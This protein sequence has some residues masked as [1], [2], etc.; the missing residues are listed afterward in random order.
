MALEFCG[1]P[2]VPPKQEQLSWVDIVFASRIS[3]GSRQEQIGVW[4]GS[5]S[6]ELCRVRAQD[7]HAWK[8]MAPSRVLGT[9][10]VTGPSWICRR[11]PL[12]AGSLHRGESHPAAA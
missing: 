10:I 12:G 1:E 8:C 5:S 4:E 9:G 7:S 3:I 11:H 6:A 2:C